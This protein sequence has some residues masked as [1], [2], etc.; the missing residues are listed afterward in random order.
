M[1]NFPHQINKIPRLT[2]AIRVFRNLANEGCNLADDGV[3]GDRLVLQRVYTFLS[4][5]A[6]RDTLESLLQIEHRK[7]SANQGSRTCARELRRLFFMLGYLTS[8]NRIDSNAE[9]L[10]EFAEPLGKEARAIWKHALE[11]MKLSDNSG[12]SHPYQ[13]LL[14]LVAEQPGIERNLLGLCFEAKDDSD[15]EFQRINRLIVETS[16]PSEIWKKLDVSRHQ[17]NNSTKILPALALQVEDIYENSGEYF[18]SDSALSRAIQAVPIKANRS[19]AQATR[20]RYDANRHRQQ[21]VNKG[22][23]VAFRS[24][25]PDAS[26]KRYIAHEECLKSFSQLFNSKFVQWESDYDLL[27]T[28]DG[29]MLLAEIKTIRHDEVR[30]TRLGLGQLLYYDFMRVEPISDGQ[31][32]LLILVSDRILSDDIVAF[33]EKHNVGVLW[34]PT[35][36]NKIGCSELGRKILEIFGIGI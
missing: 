10:C 32:I 16:N 12:T 9:R 29:E 17:A 15:N 24:Y 14:R 20:R 21:S 2:E 1:K 3:V 35:D 13:I 22:V 26:G 36:D 27:V 7:P 33:L 8:Q 30:Q 25:D 6:R 5:A 4:T 19:V 28:S 11:N 34:I 23:E 31:K 18:L